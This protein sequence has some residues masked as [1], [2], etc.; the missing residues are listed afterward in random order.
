MAIK[1]VREGGQRARVMK[2]GG[3]FLELFQNFKARYHYYPGDYPG[4]GSAQFKDANGNSF[5]GN[6]DGIFQNTAALPEGLYAWQQLK[7]TGTYNGNLP[8]T[9]N[10]S[11]GVSLPGV[12]VESSQLAGAGWIPMEFFVSNVTGVTFSNVLRLGVPGNNQFLEKAIMPAEQ[13]LALDTKADDGFPESGVILGASLPADACVIKGPGGGTIYNPA[14]QCN[15]NFALVSVKGSSTSGGGS[16]SGSSSGICNTGSSGA[17]ECSNNGDCASFCCYAGACMTDSSICERSGSSGGAGSSGTSSGAGS[18]SGGSS[19]GSTD[20]VTNPDSYFCCVQTSSVAAC[21]SKYPAAC[22]S[23]SGSGSSSGASSG[24]SSGISSGGTTS[25]SSSSSSSSSGASSG[26]SSGGS[27]SSTSSGGG[28]SGAS[29]G[30]S[31]GSGSNG[32]GSG[33]GSDGGSGGGSGGNQ[34]SHGDPCIISTGQPHVG[35]MNPC[36]DTS[37]DGICACYLCAT[38]CTIEPLNMQCETEDTNGIPG[39]LSP[40]HY[41]LSD[42]LGCI[43]CPYVPTPNCPPNTPCPRSIS[44]CTQNP[45]TTGPISPNSAYTTCLGMAAAGLTN[46]QNCFVTNCPPPSCVSSPDP[47]CSSSSSS[48]SGGCTYPNCGPRCPSGTGP[49]MNPNTQACCNGN[50]YWTAG[51]VNPDHPSTQACCANRTVYNTPDQDCCGGQ[52]INVTG[53]GAQ[54]CCPG[55]PN[56]PQ[57]R[58]STCCTAPETWDGTECSCPNGGTLVNGQCVCTAGQVECGTVCCDQAFGCNAAGDACNACSLQQ[59]NS[60]QCKACDSATGMCTRDLCANQAPHTKCDGQGGCVCPDSAPNACGNACCSASQ[61]CDGNGACVPCTTA[62]C[63]GICCPNGQ[64]CNNGACSAPATCGGIQ[65]QAGQICCGGNGTTTSP[66]GTPTLPANCC[67]GTVI[68]PNTQGCCSGTQVYTLANQCCFSGTVQAGACCPGGQRRCGNVCCPLANG[69]D[70]TGLACNTCLSGQELCSSLPPTN[71]A[72]AC[73]PTG[74]CNPNRGDP[75]QPMC[76]SSCPA[77]SFTTQSACMAYWIQYSKNQCNAAP[78]FL[79]ILAPGCIDSP[80]GANHC[81]SG[82]FGGCSTACMSGRGNGASCQLKDGTS[83]KCMGPSPAQCTTPG[84]C[85]RACE[86]DLDCIVN[87]IVPTGACQNGCCTNI[88]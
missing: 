30:A 32:S 54:Q 8:A 88:P 34:C 67:N 61:E 40:G 86:D 7:A 80:M 26:A 24:N 1:N 3:E 58:N 81:W 85:T 45:C 64:S 65:L 33:G 23:S 52:V 14:G 55:N 28:S 21:C 46:M 77:G 84:G 29:S 39:C 42:P 78:Y 36:P 62:L 87:V 9:L 66:T 37:P 56:F 17:G 35:I 10:S 63:N 70:T 5:V 6:G 76:N 49:V 20:C 2:E 50:I 38:D 59:C 11:S 4:D 44:T 18:G 48:S 74:Q 60:N 57:P 71:N 15:V 79:D 16:G 83:G 31:S 68:D 25:S 13:V 27:S 47:S 75:G 73:C 82:G 43:G 19:S 53:P 69:C 72:A 12:N 22:S 41:W 51:P